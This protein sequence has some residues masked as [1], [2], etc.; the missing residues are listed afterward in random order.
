MVLKEALLFCGGGGVYLPSA[1]TFANLISMFSLAA[2]CDPAAFGCH[3]QHV[4][5]MSAPM[6]SETQVSRSVRQTICA[7]LLLSPGHAALPSAV[8]RLPYILDGNAS[9]HI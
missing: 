4:E 8:G 1:V 7:V 6:P 9:Q 2:R 3:K 5:H